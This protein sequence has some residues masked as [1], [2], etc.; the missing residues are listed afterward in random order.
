MKK[1]INMKKAFL[2]S[3]FLCA[4]LFPALSQDI[5]KGKFYSYEPSPRQWGPA[6]SVYEAN[7]Q[8]METWQSQ[9]FGRTGMRYATGP[10]QPNGVRYAVSP[11]IDL[12][13]LPAHTEC[14][15]AM[16]ERFEVESD[17]DYVSVWVTD[18]A[19]GDSSR[20]YVR[21][22]RSEGEL[23]DFVPLTDYAGKRIRLTFRLTS[24]SGIEGAGW[25]LSRLSILTRP[26][27]SLRKATLLSSSLKIQNCGVT[28]SPNGWV[29]VTLAVTDSSGKPVT[30]L[31]ASAFSIML[32]SCLADSLHLN[33]ESDCRPVDVIFAVDNSS[34][35][36]SYQYKVQ[37][38]M[39]SLIDSLGKHFQTS[40]ALLRFGQG[41]IGDCPYQ[42]ET[43]KSQSMFPIS[44]N[45]NRNS[46]IN[47]IWVKNKQ[48]GDYEPYYS[49]LIKSATHPLE[50]TPMS[51]KVIIMLGDEQVN[52]EQNY[53]DCSGAKG[54][55]MQAV[56]DTLTVRGFQTFIIGTPA[57]EG[58]FQPIAQATGG[59]MQDI[60]NSEY[61]SLMSEIARKLSNSYTLSFKTKCVSCASGVVDMDVTVTKDGQTGSVSSQTKV[62]IPA[63]IS[64]SAQTEALKNVAKGSPVSLVYHLSHN[65]C[66]SVK[67]FTIYY[68]YVKDSVTHI[69]SA[70]FHTDDSLYECDIPSANVTGRR[71]DYYAKAEMAN[72]TSISVS[73]IVTEDYMCWNFAVLDTAPEVKSVRWT[74]TDSPCGSKTVTAT[75]TDERAVQKVVLYYRAYGNKVGIFSRAEM[76]RT[77]NDSTYSVSV[78]SI[79][80][81]EGISYYI[82]AIDDDST[83]GWYGLPE[84][85]QTQTFG[86]AA[87][88][89]TVLRTLEIE[90]SFDCNDFF[91]NGDRVT[92][93]YKSSCGDYLVPCG[94]SV[95]TGKKFSLSI[96]K[97]TGGE[98]GTKNGADENDELTFVFSRV[99]GGDT[100][101]YIVRDADVQGNSL[102]FCPPVDSTSFSIYHYGTN[103]LLSN[104][105][106]LRMAGGIQ[107]FRSGKGGISQRLV[108]RSSSHRGLLI[109]RMQIKGSGLFT[110]DSSYVDAE[111]RDSLVFTLRYN[112]QR[113]ACD[114]LYIYSNSPANPYILYL[115]G[116]RG[117]V[118][119]DCREML[120]TVQIHRSWNGAMVDVVTPRN[121]VMLTI[122][123]SDE[124]GDTLSGSNQSFGPQLMSGPQVHSLWFNIAGLKGVYL[125][126][127]Q[128]DNQTCDSYM[129]LKDVPCDDLI[130]GVRYG[131]GQLAVDINTYGEKGPLNLHIYNSEGIFTGDNAYLN[132]VYGIQTLYK[133]A[134]LR[135]GVYMLHVQ[136]DNQNECT[137]KFVVQ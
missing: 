133:T 13:S 49:V 80:D 51:Q 11:V 109:N 61:S 46:F 17:F 94:F 23:T 40:A 8:Q 25:A 54:P 73:P 68:Q 29:K 92:A 20:I 114:T 32:N 58:Q 1:N 4:S 74:G 113:E 78:D 77:G 52:D 124:N 27:E 6:R 91:N 33:T 108:L 62:D 119:S 21:T 90:K 89:T 76:S 75:V 118:S 47:D 88:S 48:S 95:Y 121:N 38:T 57:Y 34:S 135:P 128:M 19:T 79:N 127:I 85:P 22:G 26:S 44:E 53:K 71:I 41:S 123:M 2:L 84:H 9:G 103:I 5:Q 107:T 15:L 86:H 130:T 43:L 24:D 65:T 82:Y 67:T 106:T 37:N 14:R 30:G 56:I 112:P 36:S 3:L 7:A 28:Y 96:S 102:S 55:S 64:R 98:D 16:T 131:N 42:W 129:D 63:V 134:A 104:G 69:D 132:D 50:Y 116:R 59:T 70:V 39:V 35:M 10:Y 115:K 72:S 126:H 66:D 101:T 97:N 125:L 105:D 18:V 111:V 87:P 83:Q 136:Y 93:F 81:W 122:R 12:T 120:D 137:R 60:G 100:M 45:T 31:D 99:Y 117:D 110:L